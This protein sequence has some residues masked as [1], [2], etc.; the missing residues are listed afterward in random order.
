MQEFGKPH[1]ETD[2]APA[3][4]CQAPPAA[5]ASAGGGDSE[6]TNPLTSAVNPE[7]S[8]PVTRP[9]EYHASVVREW[10][11]P[12]IIY[13]TVI[14][15]D[16][17]TE[18]IPI[19][20]S[21]Q[22]HLVTTHTE[23]SARL[24]RFFG[25]IQNT[26]GLNL[27]RGDRFVQSLGI[28]ATPQT[29][30]LDDADNTAFSLSLRKL[31]LISPEEAAAAVGFL[32]YYLPNLDTTVTIRNKQLETLN[33]VE[34]SEAFRVHEQVHSGATR[35]WDIT[36]K[37]GNSYDSN[38]TTGF[39]HYL[40]NKGI[41]GGKFLLEGLAGYIAGKYVAEELDRPHGLTDAPDALYA[42]PDRYGNRILVPSRYVTYN[43]DG[44][45]MIVPADYAAT[46]VGHV[47]DKDSGL[48]PAMIAGQSSSEGFEE[49][50]GRLET[51]QPGLS[52]LLGGHFNNYP[53]FKV[54]L[55]EIRKALHIAL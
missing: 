47:I 31:N 39:Q 23:A 20:E 12:S 27:E 16:G 18:Q 35:R 11:P 41:A 2:A 34:I 21:L 38:V 22:S 54:G 53:K 42:T 15:P 14:Q 33:G 44:E 46:A 28:A 17:H 4:D 1:R 55:Q 5:I 25:P 43:P 50:T 29:L 24:M 36:I 37:D 7:A 32:S 10:S 6:I 26:E 3:F 9:H 48:L 49:M 45:R 13:T 30:A 19:P 52:A 51:I 8:K 40:Q